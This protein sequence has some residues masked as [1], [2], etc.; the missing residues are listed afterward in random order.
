MRSRKRAYATMVGEAWFGERAKG[1][2]AHKYT[3]QGKDFSFRAR[4]IA[5]ARH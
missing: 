4:Y 1:D 3:V 2:R 5:Y